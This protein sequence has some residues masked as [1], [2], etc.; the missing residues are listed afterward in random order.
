[1]LRLTIRVLIEATCC[2]SQRTPSYKAR[3]LSLFS[4]N[5]KLNVFNVRFAV[6]ATVAMNRTV[7]RLVNLKTTQHY[8]K[9]A[10]FLGIFS[11]R[12]EKN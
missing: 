12:E 1:M 8:N 4:R 3:Q 2:M 10:V 11:A 6:L 7:F 9:K 5:T